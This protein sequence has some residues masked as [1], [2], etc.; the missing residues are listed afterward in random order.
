MFKH[1]EYIMTL[2]SPILFLKLKNQADRGITW[3]YYIVFKS[4]FGKD[5]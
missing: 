4:F 3:S 1:T 5:F 2:F